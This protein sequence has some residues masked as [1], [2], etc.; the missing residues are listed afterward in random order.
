MSTFSHL[1]QSRRAGAPREIQDFILGVAVMLLERVTSK[2]CV[3]HTVTRI[4]R[5]ARRTSRNVPWQRPRTQRS[6]SHGHTKLSHS[7]QR[8]RREF[9]RTRLVESFTHALESQ[10]RWL[11]V[12]QLQ[13]KRLCN[14]Q[15]PWNSL[16]DV[17]L[18]NLE[19]NRLSEETSLLSKTSSRVTD[20]SAPFHS[21][22]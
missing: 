7:A 4:K 21:A 11:R 14:I 18:S 17:T 22:T 19:S 2:N 9:V 13:A 6:C 12:G 15:R 5:G 20:N 8:N 16:N 1:S 3:P 10:L